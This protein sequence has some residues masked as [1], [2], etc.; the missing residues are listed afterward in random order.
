MTMDKNVHELFDRGLRKQWVALRHV[1]VP[2]D[3]FDIQEVVNCYRNKTTLEI[4]QLPEMVR[5][6]SSD[7]TLPVPPSELLASHSACAEA[8]HLSGA[9]EEIDMF[10]R[11]VDKL[12]VYPGSCIF[13]D[14]PN[15][16]W[17]VSLDRQ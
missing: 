7:P 8:T 6:A 11:D 17:N 2:S 3:S 5:F 12:C 4:F 1:L 10:D 9:I 14:E 15:R 16:S 13:E